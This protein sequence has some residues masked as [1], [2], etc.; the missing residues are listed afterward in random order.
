MNKPLLGLAGLVAF[1]A[2]GGGVYVLASSGGEEEA[3]QLPSPAGSS[4][5]A[6]PSASTSPSSRPAD[7]GYSWFLAPA[8]GF[9][10]A[11]Y[12]VQIPAD[13]ENLYPGDS[14]PRWFTPTRS[15]VTQFSPKL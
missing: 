14:N 5:T 8:S 13:W 15:E 2:V 9:G 10:L 7:A 4:A 11:S 1:A 12:D 6:V 3:L